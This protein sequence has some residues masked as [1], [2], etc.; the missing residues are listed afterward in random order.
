MGMILDLDKIPVKSGVNDIKT[1]DYTSFAPPSATSSVTLDQSS[2]GKGQIIRKVIHTR[3][4]LTIYPNGQTFV[5]KTQV[6]IENQTYT[7]KA[8]KK[9]NVEVKKTAIQQKEEY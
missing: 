2:L 9:K 5:G 7:P 8:K 6:W 1:K 3:Q 4:E